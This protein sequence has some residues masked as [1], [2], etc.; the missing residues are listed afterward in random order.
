MSLV[1]LNTV[2]GAFCPYFARY[3]RSFGLCI[4]DKPSF[5]ACACNSS[6][7][8]AVYC[9]LILPPHAVNRRLLSMSKTAAMKTSKALETP[10]A[11]AQGEVDYKAKIDVVIETFSSKVTR[12]PACAPVHCCAC[13]MP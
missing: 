7:H 9:P 8:Q 10:K 13:T 3:L 6:P 12:G 2:Y 4:D 1:V 5:P 11:K